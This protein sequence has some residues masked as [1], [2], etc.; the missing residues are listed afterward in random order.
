MFR[1]FVTKGYLCANVLR[2]WL[3]DLPKK[4]AS[5]EDAATIEKIRAVGSLSWEATGVI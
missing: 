4:F 2:H 1:S 3:D 5:L